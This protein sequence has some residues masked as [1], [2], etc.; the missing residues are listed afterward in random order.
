MTSKTTY[1]P[2]KSKNLINNTILERV[3]CLGGKIPY[4][5]EKDITSKI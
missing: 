3:I 2:I 5:K 4:E 1:V